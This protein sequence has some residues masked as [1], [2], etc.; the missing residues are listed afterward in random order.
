MESFLV[1]DLVSII[2]P[3]YNSE[4][5]IG[6]SIRS[7]LSQTYDKWELFVIDDCSTD[8]T[9]DVVKGFT[10]PRVK[11]IRLT[12]NSGA[13]IARNE[14]LNMA[15][16]RYI[17][18]LDADD[19]WKPTKLASQLEFMER[20]NIGFSYTAYEILREGRN[21]LIR[22]PAKLTYSQFMKNTA[23]GTL[24]VMLDRSITGAFRIVDVRKDHD[25]MTWAKLLRSGHVA[26]GL[27]DSL[28]YYRKVQGSIS[29]NKYRAVKTHWGNCR[30]IEN[31]SLLRCSYYFSFYLA[32]A[33][34]K[35][36]L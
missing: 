4:R 28:A 10:D 13:A 30:R 22:V 20:H 7:V 5:F 9:G 25:S 31:L 24:T 3:A 33:I 21:K 15:R 6:D 8:K 34:K 32:N 18:F 35:H 11:Y 36:Y 14:A 29:N 12:S 23:I 19:M 27:R 2:T 26:H 1:D 16:G 17:A